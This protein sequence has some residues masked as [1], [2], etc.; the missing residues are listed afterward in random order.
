MDDDDGA[1]LNNGSKTDGPGPKFATHLRLL[2]PE[3]LDTHPHNNHL[4]QF[5]CKKILA[6]LSIF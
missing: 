2:R 5:V 6:P 3:H 1:E 4:P